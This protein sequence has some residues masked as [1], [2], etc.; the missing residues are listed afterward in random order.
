MSNVRRRLA[1]GADVQPDGGVHFRVW[2][3]RRRTVEVAFEEGAAPLRLDTEGGGYFS[4]FAPRAA[5]G[6]RYRYRLDGNDAFPDPASRF[7]PE[8]PHCPS[9]VVDPGRF[10]WTDAARS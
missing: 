1:V 10:A 6:A 8:G 4:G 9:E 2:A 5:A 7:Q 3:P